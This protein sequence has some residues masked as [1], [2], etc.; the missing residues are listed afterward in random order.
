[1]RRARTS[2]TIAIGVALLLS[3]VPASAAVCDDAGNCAIPT[4][5]ASCRSFAVLMTPSGEVAGSEAHV[6][7]PPGNTSENTHIVEVTHNNTFPSVR[8]HVGGVESFCQA[9]TDGGLRR[10]CGRSVIQD[11]MLNLNPV[12][13]VVIQARGIVSEGCSSA[14]SEV[15]A[16][17]ESHI[18]RLIVSIGNGT[19]PLD[20]DSLQENT[21]LTL[22]GGYR[23]IVNG[24]EQSFGSCV[25][26]TGSTLHLETPG[27]DIIV[28]W[29]STNA[30]P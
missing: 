4:A 14:G 12:Q 26:S 22:G 2:W 20:I 10:A 28:G 15:G 7:T 24:S 5:A 13:R 1:M 9:Y 25:R 8:V 18:G 3:A 23:L 11:L 19:G 27:G 17:N 16:Y 30:C 6:L 21:A 29:V